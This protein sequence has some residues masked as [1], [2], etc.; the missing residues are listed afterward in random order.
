MVKG[1]RGIGGS[2][3]EEPEVR[4]VAIRE[5]LIHKTSPPHES[6]NERNGLVLILQD[7]GKPK[8]VSNSLPSCWQNQPERYYSILLRDRYT[9]VPEERRLVVGEY[10]TKAGGTIV[11]GLSRISLVMLPHSGVPFHSAQPGRSSTKGWRGRIFSR[12]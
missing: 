12:C 8:R 7:W 9:R 2:A 11:G 10:R 4:L 3:A 6:P 1:V 5:G